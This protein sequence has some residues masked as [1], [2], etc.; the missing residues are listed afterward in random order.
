MEEYTIYLIQF[1]AK[2]KDPRSFYGAAFVSAESEKEAVEML[3][4][5]LNAVGG[6]AM[7]TAETKFSASRK[8]LRLGW[9]SDFLEI[10]NP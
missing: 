3:E 2:I 4:E 8:D 7:Q 1:D 5:K 9:D 10:Y 6:K